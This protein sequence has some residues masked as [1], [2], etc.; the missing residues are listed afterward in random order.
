M[1]VKRYRPKIDKLFYIIWV[2]TGLLMLALTL[3][4]AIFELKTLF[5]TLPLDL[6][7]FYFLFSSLVGYA[8]LRETSLFIRYGFI[9]K[10]EIPYSEICGIEKVRRWYSETMLS[11]KNSMEHVNIKYKRF[12]ITAVSV[13]DNDGFIEEIKARIN[14]GR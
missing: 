5:W 8:E 10:K 11:L 13:K 1:Q 6:F 4:T 14:Y 2:P 9:L 12:D 3:V 7:V